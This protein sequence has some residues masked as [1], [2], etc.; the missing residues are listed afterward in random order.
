MDCLFE[1][2]DLFVALFAIMM[3]AQH[4]GMAASFGPDM[5]KAAAAAV[6]IFGIAE[7]P[8]KIDAI[9]LDDDATKERIDMSS[10]NGKIEFKNVWFRYP[11]RKADFV[12]KGLDLTIEAGDSVALVGE[13]GCGKSTFVNLMMRFYDPDQGEILLDGKNIKNLNLHDLRNAVSLVMQE[14]VIFNY[15]ILEN[16]LYSKTDASND[17]ILEAAHTANAMEFIN[18]NSL[19]QLDD[20]VATLIREMEKN[21]DAL[22]AVIGQKKYDEE[23]DLLKKVEAHEVKK[24]TF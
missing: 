13:S 18:A 12:L 15:T 16:I 17:Q 5:G 3:G 19:N 23:F 8:S 10:I 2:E 11:T 24:G 4:A 1:P 21:K 9:A 6:R 20:D 22:V 7:Y 14:P